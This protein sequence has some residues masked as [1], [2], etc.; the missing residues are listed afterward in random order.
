MAEIIRTGELLRYCTKIKQ[1]SSSSFKDVS[2][3]GLVGLNLLTAPGGDKNAQE[4]NVMVPWFEPPSRTSNERER[5]RTSLILNDR[6]KMQRSIRR[7]GE[8]QD[9]GRVLLLRCFPSPTR[10]GPP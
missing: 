4:I 5:D 7:G 8:G 6:M 9:R 10:H 3:G 1:C 2:K